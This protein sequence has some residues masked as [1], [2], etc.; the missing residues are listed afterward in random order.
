MPRLHPV[1]DSDYHARKLTAKSKELD[2]NPFGYGD[3]RA[4]HRSVCL[5]SLKVLYVFPLYVW[6]TTFIKY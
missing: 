4:H 6:T 3:G 5:E 1:D 2:L